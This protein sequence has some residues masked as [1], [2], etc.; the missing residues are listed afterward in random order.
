MPGGRSSAALLATARW[1]ADAR[2]AG[3]ERSG[4]ARPAGTGSLGGKGWRSGRL[5]GAELC[6]MSG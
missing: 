5:R 4:E 6:A 2:L 1:R 3:A